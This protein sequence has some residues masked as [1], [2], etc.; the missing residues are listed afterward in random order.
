MS[1]TEKPIA[2]LIVNSAQQS[3]FQRYGFRM[4]TMFFW[5]VFLSLFRILLT[6]FLWYV[7]GQRV[8]DQLIVHV[9]WPRISDLFLVYFLVIVGIGLLLIGWGRYNQYRFTRKER[10]ID[11]LAPAG[12]EAISSFFK[13][14]PEQVSAAHCHRRLVLLHGPEGE[15][16]SIQ[17]N[18]REYM[19]L[20]EPRILQ[21]EKFSYG[22]Y[23]CCHDKSGQWCVTDENVVVFQ[24]DSID[25]CWDYIDHLRDMPLCSGGG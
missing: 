10:R 5:L 21:R 19:P 22:G 6:P 16:S 14:T 7:S 25:C 23:L 1:R 13:V 8:Y 12:V 11:F 20:K 3:H 18:D 24:S 9:D 2:P 17:M 15:L 4:L